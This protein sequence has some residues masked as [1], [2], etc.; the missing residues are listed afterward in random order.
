MSTNVPTSHQAGPAAAVASNFDRTRRS[1]DPHTLDLRQVA[2]LRYDLDQ[3]ASA[4]VALEKRAQ[5]RTMTAQESR[6]A[7]RLE[8]EHSAIVADLDRLAA[9]HQTSQGL[10]LRSALVGAL[11]S[12]PDAESTF[13]VRLPVTS[14]VELRGSDVLLT[15]DTDQGAKAVPS[16]TVLPEL[17]DAVA[18]HDGEFLSAVRTVVVATPPASTSAELVTVTNFEGVSVVNEGASITTGD[19]TFAR[20]PVSLVKRAGLAKVS[21]E[22]V[23]DAVIDAEA[24]VVSVHE[25]AHRIAGES[26]LYAAG[27]AGAGTT[28]T[29][30]SIDL[31]ALQTAAGTVNDAGFI[32]DLVVL[33]PADLTAIRKAL[34]IEAGRLP[35]AVGAQVVQSSSV[36]AGHALALD[37]RHLVRVQ[38][39]LVPVFIG[40]NGPSVFDRD[41]IQV[42]TSVRSGAA[43]TQAAA[44]VHIDKA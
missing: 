28:T 12:G 18:G 14:G 29:P 13:M 25:R 33:A 38:R 43:V 8:A 5:G 44:V 26:V 3:V 19:V 4:Q 2:G 10:T 11:E 16:V 17:V 27:I 37:S 35:E 20:T 24:A 22:L 32:C 23:E 9:R 30:A 21:T 31:A 15:T 41:L 39:N 6:Q 40:R 34:G 1:L 36:P 42:R 7:A